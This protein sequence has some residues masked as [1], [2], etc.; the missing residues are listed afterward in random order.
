[1][2]DESYDEKV[3][4]WSIGITALELAKGY[5]PYSKLP[6]MKVAG[7]DSGVVVPC[8]VSCLVFLLVHAHTRLLVCVF[9]CSGFAFEVSLAVG[10]CGRL[11]SG[12]FFMA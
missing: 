12:A 6:P 1:M 8:F 4:I 10:V 2:Q 11:R 5:A 9:V 3:D 7:L